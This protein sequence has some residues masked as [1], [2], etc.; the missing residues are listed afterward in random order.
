MF[1]KN[2]LNLEITLVDT[3]LDTATGGRLKR[4]SQYIDQESAFAFR[5]ATA[6]QM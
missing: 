6:Y 4:V 1:I 3:G 2:M 5:T